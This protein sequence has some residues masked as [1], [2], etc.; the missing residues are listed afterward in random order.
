MGSSVA[1]SVAVTTRRI[2]DG[3][4]GGE[5]ANSQCKAINQP[6]WS[7][8][9]VFDAQ[10]R[11][12][13]L[14]DLDQQPQPSTQSSEP[15]REQPRLFRPRDKVLRVKVYEPRFTSTFRYRILALKI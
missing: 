5:G 14:M 4:G 7:L 13:L 2:T 10:P 3:R 1:V 15:K 8:I 9:I 11:S 6:P 12:G